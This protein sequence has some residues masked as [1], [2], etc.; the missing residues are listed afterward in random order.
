MLLVVRWYLTS[1]FFASLCALGKEAGSLTVG[2]RWFELSAAVPRSFPSAVA[3]GP[4]Q[5]LLVVKLLGTPEKKK[6][7][8]IHFLV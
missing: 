8:F 2:A 7:I 5:V 3:R 1:S 6:Y 4:S